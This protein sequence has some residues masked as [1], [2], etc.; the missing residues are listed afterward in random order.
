MKKQKEQKEQLFT[1]SQLAVKLPP[2]KVDDINKFGTSGTTN[3]GTYHNGM[4]M[5]DLDSWTD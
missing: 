4:Y 1:P 3:Q 5:T 2:V